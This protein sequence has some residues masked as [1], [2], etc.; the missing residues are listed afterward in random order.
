MLWIRWNVVC[1]D[2]FRFGV[3]CKRLQLA[4]AFFDTDVPLFVYLVVQFLYF[5]DLDEEMQ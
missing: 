1:F 5:P 3:V 4:D 2:G